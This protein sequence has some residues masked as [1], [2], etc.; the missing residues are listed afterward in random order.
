MASSQKLSNKTIFLLF[1][2]ILTTIFNLVSAQHSHGKETKECI[3][4][5]NDHDHDHD[6][7]EESNNGSTIKYKVGAIVAILCA[8]AFGV[9][10]P[11]LG[12]NIPG[13]R[14]DKSTFVIVKTFA[15]GVIL[16]TAL[17]HILP[18]AFENLTNPCI[19][20]DSVVLS[21]PF[22]GVAVMVGAL[23][24]L[25]MDCLATRHFSGANNG[26]N[27][28]EED[29]DGDV[30]HHVHGSA[31]H[32]PI[33]TGLSRVEIIRYRVTSQVFFLFFYLICYFC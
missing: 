3:C 12:K 13:L 17:I 10:L 30:H 20:E 28:D 32:A 2:L 24:T 25:I 14:P 19:G 16:C 27:G 5:K 29:K 9:F 15:A 1:L 31:S 21:F 23:L 7:E 8:S 18:E 4:L 6:H 22:T 11:I 26:G 33:P